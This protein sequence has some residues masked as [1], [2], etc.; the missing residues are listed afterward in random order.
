MWKRHS[1]RLLKERRPQRSWDAIKE[2]F[3]GSLAS[4]R[5]QLLDNMHNLAQGEFEIAQQECV[6]RVRVLKEDCE[7]SER[8][9]TLCAHTDVEIYPWTE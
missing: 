3:V 8:D 6:D 9:I 7:E 5:P 4:Y 1:G 2:D